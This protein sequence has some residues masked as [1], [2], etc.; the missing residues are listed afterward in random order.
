[1]YLKLSIASVAAIALAAGCSLLPPAPL[2]HPG[3]TNQ[4][5]GQM[6]AVQ[7]RIDR[8]W[9]TQAIASDVT[10]AKVTVSVPGREPVI[11]TVDDTEWATDSLDIGNLP[12]GGDAKIQV[13]A[14]H[15]ATRIGY[16]EVMVPLLIGRR[17]TATVRVGLDSAGRT[18]LYPLSPLGKLPEFSA[19]GKLMGR[20]TFAQNVTSNPDRMLRVSARY[21]QTFPW[22]AQYYSAGDVNSDPNGDFLFH[23]L[24]TASYQVTCDTYAFS[25]PVVA[26]Y[27]ASD[28]ILVEASQS[29][30]PKMGMEIAWNMTKAEP[31]ANTDLPGR[32]VTFSW[33]PKP[34]V[35]NPVYS[36][37]LRSGEYGSVLTTTATSS[38]TV[39]MMAIPSS[40]PA[41]TYYY[42]VQYWKSGGT[43]GGMN[44]YGESRG[45]PIRVPPAPT[46]SPT[47][48]ASGSV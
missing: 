33:P 29:V 37:V 42:F 16:G 1:M 18:D 28:P 17:T 6:A 36:V 31:P 45:I 20:L 8:G 38:N 21:W 22:G 3:T 48:T 13:E 40:V 15:V 14:F 9:Q 23:D 24:A 47:P 35:V 4:V 43:Y 11:K 30:I 19:E 44:Y 32:N 27:L 34:G 46:P 26:R 41:G 39:A 10:G 12:F 5:A 25:E 7:L 2:T